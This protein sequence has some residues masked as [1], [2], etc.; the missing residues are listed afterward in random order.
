[1]SPNST[2]W[3]WWRTVLLLILFLSGPSLGQAKTKGAKG[4]G[5][6]D[7]QGI[8]RP[9][10]VN[11]QTDPTLRFPVMSKSG[12]ITYGWLDITSSTIRYTEVQPPRKSGHAFEVSRFAISDLRLNKTELSFKAD[13][14]WQTLIYLPQDRWGSVHTAFG[15]VSKEA[16]RDSLG[17]LSIYKTLLNF[18]GVLALVKPPPP[19]PAPVTVQ[20]VAPASLPKPAA[21]PPPPAIVLSSPPGAAENHTLEWGETTVVIRGVA[22]DSTGIPVVRIN[23]A[24]ANM[25]PQTT[26]AAEFWSDPLP[27]KV[28][29]N[30]IQI[31]ASNTAHVE[32][33]VDLTVHYKPKAAPVNPRALGKD[34]IISLLQGSVP[35]ARIADLVKE[36][37][38]KFSPSADDLKAI[39]AAG[40]TDDLIEAIQQAAPHS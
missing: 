25:R 39:R 4:G 16:N 2:A 32:A 35:P 8:I 3:C 6:S 18:D 36:R 21:P 26:Q 27:L 17:T 28:G 14:K 31:V 40:G 15:G 5:D 29:S 23:G 11:G 24:P 20:P 7:L 37:G 38:I 22:M 12:A 34:E 19:P 1:M 30:R 9:E 10:L 33:K 13:K